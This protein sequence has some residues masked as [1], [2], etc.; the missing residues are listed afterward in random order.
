MIR[1]PLPGARVALAERLERELAHPESENGGRDG[2]YPRPAPRLR[3]RE[4]E[5]GE[6]EGEEEEE[7]SQ[8]PSASAHEG[9]LRIRLYNESSRGP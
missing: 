7:R 1:G 6:A 9:S 4:P 3:S 2:D 5:P 8:R